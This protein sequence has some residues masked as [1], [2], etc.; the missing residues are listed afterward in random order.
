MDELQFSYCA[1]ALAYPKNGRVTI[2]GYHLVH[3]ELLEDSELS[4]DVKFPMKE[5][6]I[7]NLLSRQTSR[8]IGFISVSQ[9][10]GG[11]VAKEVQSLL[12]ES[13]EIIVF[14]SA[15]G[16]DL[17]A[18]SD[19]LKTQEKVLWVGSAGLA[20]AL[21]VNRENK[22][23]KRKIIESANS[24]PTLTIAG[25]VS[26][27]TREQIAY[28]KKHGAHTI[29]IHP[30]HLLKDV[31]GALLV[32]L[33]EAKRVLA[34]GED[35]VVTTQLSKVVA[36]EVQTYMDEVEMD[37]FELGNTIA[38]KLG[39]LASRIIKEVEVSGLILTGGDIAYQTCLRLGIDALEVVMEIEEGIPLCRVIEGTFANTAVVTKAGAFGHP[40]SLHNAMSLIKKI[41][42]RGKRV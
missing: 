38:S 13:V 39:Q 36:E 5:S 21:S 7:P 42:L 4:K 17:E 33:Q 12:S 35:L 23:E 40:I 30:L 41:D 32:N 9:L 16:D 25:S 14:D 10:R 11:T 6:F 24:L 27:V 3:G 8:K 29:A 1:L 34:S 37:S 18:V 31:E 19:F 20:Y 2:G 26:K 15:T 28:Q 22:V